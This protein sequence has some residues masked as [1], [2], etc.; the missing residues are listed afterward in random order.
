MAQ[1]SNGE[2]TSSTVVAHDDAGRDCELGV[3]NTRLVVAYRHGSRLRF[4]TQ[5][6]DGTWQIELVD[7]GL[8]F[9]GHEADL[10]VHNN[11]AVIA[12]RDGLLNR[13][14]LSWKINGQWTTHQVESVGVSTGYRPT[15]F[16]DDGG[17]RVYYGSVPAD[18]DVGS[19]G[20]LWYLGGR[21]G[22]VP[23]F[24]ACLR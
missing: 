21:V 17:Y 5:S 12:H 18:P 1:L 2:W 24:P 15:L 8:N 4:A 3:L 20:T 22:D 23:G 11:Q 19:D 9:A 16:V 6:A 7:G 13:L 14:R 10:V